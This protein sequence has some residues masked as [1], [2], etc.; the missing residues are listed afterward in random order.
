MFDKRLLLVVMC[1]ALSSACVE[2]RSDTQEIIDNL[3]QAGFA[4]D[5]ITVVDGV[6]HVGRDA[7]VSLAA[8]R[9]MRG[10]RTSGKEQYHTTN[11][12][13]SSVTKICIDGSTF[14]GIFGTALDLAI[15]NYNDLQLNVAMA[16]APSSGCDATINAVIAPGVDGGFSGFPS[17]GLPFPTINIGSPVSAHGVNTLAHVITHEL[18]HTIGLRHTDFFNR[19]ISCGA[20][21]PDDD[22]THVGAIHIPGTPT[23]ATVGGSVMNSCFRDMESGKFTASDVTA[24]QTLYPFLSFSVAFQANTGR[25]WTMDRG[26]AGD[27]GFGMMPG[28][29]PSIAR[30]AGGYQTAFQANTGSLWTMGPGGTGDVGLGMMPATSPSIAALAGGGFQIAFQ[31]NT[32]TLWTVGAAGTSDTGLVMMPGTSPSI[33]AFSGGGFEIAFQANTGFLWV[34]GT[35]GVGNT[36]FGMKTG[37][38]PSITALGGG[39]QIAF[40]ANTGTLWTEGAAGVSDTGF[41]MMT[42]T[43]PSIT[44]LGGGY[45]VAFQANTGFLWTTG[46]AG[47]GDTGFGMKAGTSPSITALG[48]G[49]QVAFQANTGHLWTIGE[50]AKGDSGLAMAANTSASN[51]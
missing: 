14:T 47:T 35:A 6:V 33:T 4:P 5:D 41:G 45:Q 48:G 28:T 20:G 21:G 24:L 38:S 17:G 51:H 30:F 8:S 44:A 26:G 29:S 40:Q 3:A 50:V 13:R 42:G 15:Q 39:Y 18:G 12:I 34:A 32:G 11:L 10:T 36:G 27:T 2:Q 49:Y 1:S 16:R 43:S 37:T 9:E 25:L 19:S 7:E 22:P 23:G 46:G 31:A